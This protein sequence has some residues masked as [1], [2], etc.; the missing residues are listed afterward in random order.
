MIGCSC[1]LGCHSR[2]DRA[3]QLVRNSNIDHLD[4]ADQWL[5]CRQQK[6]GLGSDKSKSLFRLEAGSANLTTVAV[7]PTGDIECHTACRLL[8]EPANGIVA[9]RARVAPATRAKQRVDIPAGTVGLLVKPRQVLPGSLQPVQ[10]E[11]GMMAPGQS[12][13]VGR[14]V[15][16]K[17]GVRMAKQHL[18][19]V[20]ELHKVTGH[21]QAV[22][23]V[24]SLSTKDHDMASI[25]GT[26]EVIQQHRR[27]P[28]SLFHQ[29]E[30]GDSIVPRGELVD[31]ASLF[32]CKEVHAD[33]FQ[34]LLACG[35]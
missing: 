35:Q 24:V 3:E 16:G 32:S 26:M 14:G 4:G 21:D 10:R 2:E 12:L 6:S 20:L 7:Q 11:P 13:Q 30:A 28:A 5:A 18:H 23:T 25:R 27:F 1:P 9:R 34:A 31:K 19:A 33:S 8:V 22:A 17:D 15:C 29:D